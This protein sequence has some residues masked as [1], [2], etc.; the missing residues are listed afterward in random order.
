VFTLLA[1]RGSI[2]SE[3]GGERQMRTTMFDRATGR[4]HFEYKGETTTQISHAVPPSAQD[5]LAALYVLRTGP[6]KAGARTTI[7]VSDNGLVYRVQMDVTGQERVTAPIGTMSTWR[8]NPAIFDNQNQP[9]GRNYAVWLSDDP[10]RLPVK[11]QG[12]LPLGSFV[13]TL[14][15]AR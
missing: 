12:D 10:R 13:L 5:A 8:V 7:P 14:R 4:A 11:M 15:D 9:V 2:Y 3:E 1:Q 6:L